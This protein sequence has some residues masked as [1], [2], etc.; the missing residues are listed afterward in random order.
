MS[1]NRY[2]KFNRITQCEH[3][4]TNQDIPSKA[5]ISRA[6]KVLRSGGIIIYPTDTL[7]GFGVMI[8]HKKAV[9][10]LYDLKRRDRKKPYSILINS[11]KQADQI[12]GGLTSREIEFFKILLPGKITVLLRAKKKLNL[13]GL[14]HMD[15]VGFR[16]P[17]S[18]LCNMLVQK[19]GSP[20]SSS[21]VNISYEPNIDETSEIV[22]KFS[23]D[24]DLFLDSGPVFSLKGSSVIDLTSSPPILVREGD[25]LK[26]EIEKK[27]NI[28]ISSKAN[29]KYVITF[30]CS[31]NICRSPMA[32]GILR[33]QLEK[34]KYAKRVEVNS[35]GTLNLPPT[36]AS[37]E[38]I[39]IAS[40]HKVNINNH[41]SSPIDREIL[42][43]ANI[44]IC[45]AAYHYNI[46][47]KNF[48][49][50]IDKIFVLKTM[51]KEE[52]ITDPSIADPIGMSETFYEKIF[53]EI[54]GELQRILPTLLV[55]IDKY[56]S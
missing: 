50:Y 56:L 42:D 1:G 53:W 43:R 14:E 2:M 28:E 33:K 35:A 40:N 44:I 37:P 7:Y 32:E 46:I 5:A 29:R 22:E 47:E 36:S 18:N 12:C 20:I 49:E 27:L 23:A 8:N 19:L 9:K 4:V 16:I 39:K 55:R 3:I 25:V 6:S 24:V 11:I 10:K 15:K 45:M 13:P 26:E 52:S 38:A 41:Q 54:E 34:T 51:D 30:V 21:S 17:D 48:P 31:G